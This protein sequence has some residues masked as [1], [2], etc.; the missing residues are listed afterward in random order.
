MKCIPWC[1]KRK[2]L[3]FLLLG[4]IT[5]WVLMDNKLKCSIIPE[6]WGSGS[7]RDQRHHIPKAVSAARL[8]ALLNSAALLRQGGHEGKAL[9]QRLYNRLFN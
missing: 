1:W 4:E 8:L 3:I 5:F 2:L 6:P 7:L 9:Q